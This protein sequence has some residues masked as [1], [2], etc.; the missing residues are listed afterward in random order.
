[1]QKQNSYIFSKIY[2]DDIVLRDSNQH[3]I[4]LRY[5]TRSSRKE[6]YKSFIQRQFE[7]AYGVVSGDSL[8]SS[9]GCSIESFLFIPLNTI[10]IAYS[11]NIDYFLVSGNTNFSR[12]RKF[13]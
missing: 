13:K 6:C 1:M 5:G 2:F 3:N 10:E 8:F 11:F 4:C 9:I 7:E 12:R